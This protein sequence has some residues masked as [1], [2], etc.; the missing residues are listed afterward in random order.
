VKPSFAQICYLLRKKNTPKRNRTEA[1]AATTS[2][3]RLDAGSRR[4][5]RKDDHVFNPKRTQRTKYTKQ[6]EREDLDDPKARVE[7]KLIGRASSLQRREREEKSVERR[8]K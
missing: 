2:T 5:K 1:Q 6:T 3:V 4:R 8:G 7:G